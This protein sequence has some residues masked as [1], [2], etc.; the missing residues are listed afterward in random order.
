[1]DE[2]PSGSISPFVP[3]ASND[4]PMDK[5]SPV[6]KPGSSPPSTHPRPTMADVLSM[7]EHLRRG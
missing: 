1:M 4:V 5:P 3:P 6:S 7:Q 2:P